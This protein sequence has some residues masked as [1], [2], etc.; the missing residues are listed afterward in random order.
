MQQNFD[1][2][3]FIV[4]AIFIL[5]AIVYV[6]RLFYIQ[7][8]DDTYQLSANNQALRHLTQYPARGLIFDRNGELLTYNEAAYNLMVIPKEVDT[9]D[10][11]AFCNLIGIDKEYFITKMKKVT[12]YS[13]FKASIFVEQIPAEQYASISEK[14]Y[15]YSGF[16]GE[17]R[18][19][20]NYPQKTAAHVLGYVSEVDANIIE[21]DNYYKKGDYIGAN[22]IERFY[23]K[24]LRGSRGKKVVMVD[25]LNRIQGS[26]KDEKYDTIAIPGKNLTLTLDAQ[27]QGYGEKLMQNK[28]GSVVAI[29]PETGEILSLITSPTYDPNLLVGRVR[30]SN[31]TALVK[32]D[33]L[34]PLF[35][36]AL[37][38]PYPPGSIYKMLQALIG[39]QEG[40]IKTNTGFTCNKRLVGCH[41][42][43]HPSNIEKAIQF[44]CNPYFYET[45]RKI[46]QQGK[47]PSIFKDAEL[48][49]IN[50][51]KHM[52][53]FGLGMRMAIDQPNVKG[54]YIP[55][56]KFYDRWYGHNRWAFSTIYSIS[57]GQGEVSVIPLQ[58]ANIAAIIANRGYYITPH[59]LKKI[60]DT[61]TIPAEY[62][63][64]HYTT[65]EQKHYD[66]VVEAMQQ[67]VEADHGTA[68]RARIDSIEVCGKTGTAE[69]P[70]GEDHSVFIAFAPKD[71]PKIAIAVYV[72]NAGFGGTWAAPIASLMIEQYLTGKIAHP[73]KETRIL[74]A[75]F[76]YPKNTK[77][78]S[79]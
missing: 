51:K 77:K 70:H 24:E 35:N 53:S 72:E 22:G 31:Y 19:L 54:G 55:D 50:W 18:T 58:M 26:Y 27:L 10:T 38:A 6:L 13:K 69:N 25:V 28:R 48:G 32:N 5:V 4:L 57:I 49:M 43:P 67:V 40:V 16:Y 52:D 23:E 17:Q 33:S 75:D 34:T 78:K 21:K 30:S 65:I 74:E 42:H 36:R 79:K 56:A 41:D 68:R 37:M 15:Q 2:R 71:N 11:I 46:I 73:E 20:R 66:V 29:E 44:S 62:T 63:T 47:D 76:L 45:F 8:L 59:L 61:D 7:V 64:K 9:L 1:N 12:K 3:K 39:L 14:L 60:E